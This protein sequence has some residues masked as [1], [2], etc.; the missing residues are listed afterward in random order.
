MR[1]SIHWPQLLVIGTLS[2]LAAWAICWY[3]FG[4]APNIGG[5]IGAFGLGYFVC[6]RP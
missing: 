5:V 4:Y 3:G 6:R 2:T 1:G